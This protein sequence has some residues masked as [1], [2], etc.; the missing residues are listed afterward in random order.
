MWSDHRQR[1]QQKRGT[2]A[3][4][5]GRAY[6]R[7]LKGK[8]PTNVIT[9]PTRD[10][11]LLWR[12]PAVVLSDNDLDECQGAQGVDLCYEHNDKDVVGVVQHTEVADDDSLH[13]MARIPVKTPDGKDIPRGLQ[14]VE[15]IRAGK[16]K[17][18]SVRYDT[19]VRQGGVVTGKRFKEISL[20]QEPFFNGCDLTVGVMASG[21]VEDSGN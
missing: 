12:D 17:G 15:E 14:M 4:V 21:S 2:Y 7:V 10:R 16:V 5:H 13:L 18:F 20:V 3:I 1:N 9:A 11:E 19:D 6:P 8:N